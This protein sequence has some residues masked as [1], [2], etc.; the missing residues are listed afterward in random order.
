VVGHQ[1]AG[2]PLA[3]PF[4]AGHMAVKPQ[5]RITVNARS[6]T[7]VALLTIAQTAERLAVDERNVMEL[8]RAGQLTLIR[9]GANRR[10]YRIDPAELDR[11]IQAGGISDNDTPPE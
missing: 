8:V 6:D 2:P 3:T 11:F 1:V 9:L 7:T 10:L 4:R 5:E